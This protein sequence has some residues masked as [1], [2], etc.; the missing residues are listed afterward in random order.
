MSWF[1]C[2]KCLKYLNIK[3][4]SQQHDENIIS[5]GNKETTN[6]I[7][8]KNPN[9]IKKGEKKDTI[10]EKKD[11]IQKKKDTIQKKKDTSIKDSHWEIIDKNKK[12]EI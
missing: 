9:S 12:I 7:T 5:E 4:Y 2:I 11:T 6:T 8:E 1:S 10:K 3:K